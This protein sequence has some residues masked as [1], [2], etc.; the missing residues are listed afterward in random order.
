MDHLNSYFVI[1]LVPEN[2]GID[3]K[4]MSVSCLEVKLCQKTGNVL[5]FERH[6]GFPRLHKGDTRGLLVCD[7][8]HVPASI[9]K[10]SACYQLCPGLGLFLA[11]ALGLQGFDKPVYGV[12]WWSLQFILLFFL[13]SCFAYPSLSAV[14]C[15]TLFYLC[16][17]QIF[18]LSVVAMN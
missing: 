12:Q 5:H 10:K 16:G 9:L 6:L 13:T 15:A 2:I 18:K 14:D 1:F 8:V 11:N 7:S 4:F 3:T 17:A